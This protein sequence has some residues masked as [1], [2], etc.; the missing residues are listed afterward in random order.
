MTDQRLP[1]GFEALEPYVDHWALP[2]ESA[3]IQQR[4]ATSMDAITAYYELMV[5]RI[6]EI[7]DYLDQFDLDAMPEPEQRLMNMALSLVEVANAV[8][9][10]GVPYSDRSCTADRFKTRVVDIST[11]VEQ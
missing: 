2:S 6:D 5:E 9:V 1:D 4:F 7:L 10:Y 11:T 3:R 8:E